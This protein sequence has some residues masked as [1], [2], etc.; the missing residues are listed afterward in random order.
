MRSLLFSLTALGIF[1]FT[2]MGGCA[3]NPVTT[4]KTLEQK[5]F[6]TYGSFQIVEE[7]AA[8]L[9]ERANPTPEAVK[10]VIR[11]ADAQTK[12]VM[13]AL[14][15]AVQAYELAKSAA[16]APPPGAVANLQSATDAAAAQLST[17][18]QAV[19]TAKPP[20]PGAAPAPV[21]T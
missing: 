14:L 4:A 10:R 20:S 13:D 7:Q 3:P 5:A 15:L 18:T 21:G 16:G 9:T 17:L 1:A 8:V 19:S 12:P 11:G 6:A 2:V